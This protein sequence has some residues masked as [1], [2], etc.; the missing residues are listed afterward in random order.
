MKRYGIVG[1]WNNGIMG[2]NKGIMKRYGKKELPNIPL[3]QHSNLPF[4]LSFTQYSSILIFQS[5]E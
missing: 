1:D 2:K 5:S 4:V 3:F